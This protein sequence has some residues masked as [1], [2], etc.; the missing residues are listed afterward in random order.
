VVV[1]KRIDFALLLRNE[2]LSRRH[3][4]AVLMII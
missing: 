3:G 2:R 4:L 1:R